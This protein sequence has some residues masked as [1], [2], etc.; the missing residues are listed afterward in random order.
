MFNTNS[1][2]LSEDVNC[3]FGSFCPVSTASILTQ[4]SPELLFP[5]KLPFSVWQLTYWWV[6]ASKKTRSEW[7]KPVWTNP[8]WHPAS[9]HIMCGWRPA[10]SSQS[11]EAR[12]TQAFEPPSHSGMIPGCACWR[13]HAIKTSRERT[14]EDH[15]KFE[16]KV[17]SQNF[18]INF[19]F[20]CVLNE[21]QKR[22]L[23][24]SWYLWGKWTY[25]QKIV[26]LA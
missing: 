6:Y 8:N 16:I 1:V 15:I 5:L 22:R 19:T 21:S 14:L 17:G 24:P 3:W 12:P 2:K 18:K 7:E 11:V 10:E 26:S 9:T 20:S 4:T 25:I 13:S 23:I